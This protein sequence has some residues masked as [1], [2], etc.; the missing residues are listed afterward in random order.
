M[1]STK[2]VW[3][4]AACTVAGVVVLPLAAAWACTSLATLS[5]NPQA[6]T[7]GQTVT[8]TGARFSSTASGAS[9]VEI[10]W[11]SST[12][13]L[14]ATVAPS[15]SGTINFSFVAPAGDAGYY[16]VIASQK[17]ATGAPV[18][19]T[20]ARATF[21]LNSPAA[22]VIPGSG[23]AVT[24]DQQA[25]IEAPPSVAF[26]AQLPA[27]QEAP[28]A[29]AVASSPA[30]PVATNAAAAPAAAP[31]RPVAVAPAQPLAPIAPSDARSADVLAPRTSGSFLGGPGLALVLIGAVALA[32]A[33]VAAA[34]A[35]K[36]SVRYATR[37]RP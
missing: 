37:R 17:T 24:V 8:A 6:G 26:A 25:S 22:Q 4:A 7:S 32:V 1:K 2:K 21:A 14:L 31:V 5:I 30:K 34:V 12:G 3:A 18:S 10:R 28:A 33:A 35:P 13:P 20:P 15:A 36:R 19:G 23:G 9:P 27:V 11:N 29:P 16:T